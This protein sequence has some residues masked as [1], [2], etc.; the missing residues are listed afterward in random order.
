[1]GTRNIKSSPRLCPWPRIV[2]L[3]I[4]GIK[5]KIQWNMRLYA[6]DTIAY[7]EINSTNDHNILHDNLD[8]RSEWLTTWSMDFNICKCA[9]HLITKKCNTS[10][11]NYA[12]FG[13]ALERVDDHEYLGVW[14]LLDL[15]LEML[16]NTIAK[17]ANNTL[18]KLRRILSP[19]SKEG[20][21]SAHLAK[22]RPL[23]VYAEEDCS[24]YNITT[25]DSLE[26]I[27][28]AAASFVHHDYRRTYPNW[29]CLF[30]DELPADIVDSQNF[31]TF[32]TRQIAFL[33]ASRWWRKCCSVFWISVPATSKWTLDRHG[34]YGNQRIKPEA[35]LFGRPNSTL[36]TK[37]AAISQ[38]ARR[39]TRP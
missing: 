20:K 32:S 21:G 29:H 4:N 3:N 13:I 23:L 22:V 26:L 39:W 5:E 10:L 17:K 30:G 15:C 6:D 19:C 1:M 38:I 18:R 7:S 34:P 33:L 28:R 36:Q 16:C 9:I 27:Q 2:P 11:R 8:T 24:P 37:S 31:W 25:A 14:I 35:T 12:I